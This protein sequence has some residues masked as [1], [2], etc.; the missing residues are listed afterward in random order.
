MNETTLTTLTCSH[1]AATHAL[2]SIP[3]PVERAD[4]PAARGVASQV[5]PLFD[6]SCARL[7]RYLLLNHDSGGLAQQLQIVGA[8]SEPV[9]SSHFSDCTIRTLREAM[10]A[11]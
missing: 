5:V 4:R 9:K 8:S 11:K 3:W 10:D 1:G 2:T 6:S 7:R